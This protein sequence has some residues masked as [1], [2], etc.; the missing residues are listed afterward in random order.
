[1][2]SSDLSA[3]TRALLHL[4]CGEL[5]ERESGTTHSASMAFDAARH[6]IAAGARERAVHLLEESAA[7]QVA[8]GLG[9]EAVASLDQALEVVTTDADKARLE[10][11]RIRA[12][13]TIGAWKKIRASIGRAMAADAQATL[14]SMEHS[15]DR[16][17]T[18]LNSS[19]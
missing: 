14:S 4:R 5:L 17:S 9:E 2:C 3:T 18:R 6:L 19:H 10:S 8:N 16:K 13:L 15:E 7:Y 12:L 1:M 11:A